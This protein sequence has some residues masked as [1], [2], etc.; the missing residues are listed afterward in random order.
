[1]DMCDI[2]NARNSHT[3]TTRTHTHTPVEKQPAAEHTGIIWSIKL[4]CTLNISIS[5]VCIGGCVCESSGYI[6]VMHTFPHTHTHTNTHN[7]KHKHHDPQTTT[8]QDTNIHVT[9]CT[10]DTHRSLAVSVWEKETVWTDLRFFTCAWCTP[11][12]PSTNACGCNACACD[13]DVIL[14]CQQ[15]VSSL[16]VSVCA[17]NDRSIDTVKFR[18]K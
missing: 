12:P 5:S 13:V 7:H 9:V 15:S 17:Q 14:W 8:K 2:N 10:L 11:P 6:I 4:V 18:A 3:N 1:M 16:G